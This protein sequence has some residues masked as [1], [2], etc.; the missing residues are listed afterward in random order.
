MSDMELGDLKQEVIHAIQKPYI[1]L[2]GCNGMKNTPIWKALV[3]K[4]IK[5]WTNNLQSSVTYEISN[6]ILDYLQ[7]QVE[8]GNQSQLRK[9]IL[10]ARPRHYNMWIEMN[11]EGI[12]NVKNGLEA[13]WIETR[14]EFTVYS[15]STGKISKNYAGYKRP[16]VGDIF[17]IDHYYQPKDTDQSAGINPSLIDTDI[18]CEKGQ[19]IPPGSEEAMPKTFKNLWFLGSPNHEFSEALEPVMDRL[20]S[21]FN[22]FIDPNANRFETFQD[23][24]FQTLEPRKYARLMA[25]LSLMNFD[26]FVQEP[27]DIGIQSLKLKR[28]VTPSD[29]HHRVVLKLPK[30]K[31]RIINPKG[32]RRTEAY[33][34]KRHQVAGHERHYRDAHGNIYKTIYIKPHWRGDASLGTI[35]KDYVVE[36]DDD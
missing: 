11:L 28:E 34:V 25:I 1:R 6:E 31:G 26:W 27:K 33:G 23:E 12:S 5:K 14:N 3:K 4:N 24:N 10:N 29:S 22:R 35:T 32:P 21:Q 15:K 30:T 2:H 13:F 36:K 9:A 7:P 17:K 16:V 18:W 19:I 8:K 20:S